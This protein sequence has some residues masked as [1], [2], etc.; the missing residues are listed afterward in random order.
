MSV[1]PGRNQNLAIFIMT[2]LAYINVLPIELY[3]SKARELTRPIEDYLA[4]TLELDG[5]T[6]ESFAVNLSALPRPTIKTVLLGGQKV[7]L[8]WL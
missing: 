7:G 3:L 2:T 5:S 4:K 1:L 6:E 8:G